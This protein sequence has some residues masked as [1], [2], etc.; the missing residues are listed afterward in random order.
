[1]TNV[2]IED[3][4][5]SIR[6]LVSSESRDAASLGRGEAASD[7]EGA[8]KLVLTPSFRVDE[9]AADA[10]Q[11]EAETG[12]R[13][14]E[15]ADAPPESQASQRE[16]DEDQERAETDDAEGA[17]AETPDTPA[18][19]LKAR[20]AELEQVVARRDDQWE[21]D[22]ASDDDYA[23]GPVA[24]LPWEDYV[25]SDTGGDADGATETDAAMDTDADADDEAD[26]S[27]AQAPEDDDEA[28]DTLDDELETPMSGGAESEDRLEEDDFLDAEPEDAILDEDALRDL[29]TEIV[30]QELQGGLGERITRNVRKLVRREIHRALASQELE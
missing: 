5:S 18:D 24:P 30:R 6:R 11:E 3:V 26:A 16:E 4:L 13:T 9:A 10:P 2:E 23:G 21:P 25:P 28:P 22:G 19:T 27:E 12:D 20:V 7:D 1:M 14:A 15:H 8:Q 29:V 17:E